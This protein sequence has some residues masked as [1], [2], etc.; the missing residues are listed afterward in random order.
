MRISSKFLIKEVQVLLGRDPPYSEKY[1]S[2]LHMCLQ[3]VAKVLEAQD[4]TIDNMRAEIERLGNTETRGPKP[5]TERNRRIVQEFKKG[6]SCADL[7][8]QYRIS[9]QRVH[10]IVKLARAKGVY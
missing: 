5:Q 2:R 4:V 1:M 10:A 7:G 3:Q 9:S 6:A 8:K